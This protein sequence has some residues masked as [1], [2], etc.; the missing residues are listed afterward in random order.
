VRPSVAVA[1]CCRC[2]AGRFQQKQ[3]E[4]VLRSY[5]LEYVTCKVCR[6]PDTVLTKENRLMFVQCQQCRANY[7]VSTIK[8]GFSAQI[9]RR[10]R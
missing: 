3:I 4:N 6:R 9:G 10:K 5:I 2:A 7:S 8:S 1:L